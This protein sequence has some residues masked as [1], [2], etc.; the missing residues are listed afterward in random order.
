VSGE[1]AEV[2]GSEDLREAAIVAQLE[3]VAAS[4]P[5]AL[6]LTAEDIARVRPRVEA[7]NERLR[8]GPPA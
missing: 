3:L 4:S 2:R 8:V 5:G 6:Q 7:L 1:H